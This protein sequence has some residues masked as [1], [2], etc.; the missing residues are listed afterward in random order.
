M[1]RMVLRAGDRGVI[2]VETARKGAARRYAVATHQDGQIDVWSV[3]ERGRQI[4]NVR[5]IVAADAPVYEVVHETPLVSIGTYEHDTPDS[6]SERGAAN[7][8]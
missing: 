7:A 1:K 6:S 8:G 3:D 4:G 2:R 5:V